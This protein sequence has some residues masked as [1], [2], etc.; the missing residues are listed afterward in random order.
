MQSTDG[1][2]AGGTNS[3]APQTQPTA[4]FWQDWRVMVAAIVAAAIIAA[5]LVIM[6]FRRDKSGGEVL[7]A[8]LVNGEIAS[9]A[10][11]EAEKRAL[12]AELRAAEAEKQVLQ[13]RLANQELRE[14]KPPSAL[15]GPEN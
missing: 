13:E 14:S 7:D 1:N 15:P 2:A 5:L 6:I 9:R 10:V 3:A 11:D 4:P 8:E 12:K